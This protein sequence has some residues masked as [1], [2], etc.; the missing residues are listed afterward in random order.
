LFH[1]PQR[2]I[3][4]Q[5]HLV[6]NE[7][8]IKQSHCIKYLGIY[9]DSNLSWKPQVEYIAKKNKKK[10][11]PLIKASVLCNYKNLE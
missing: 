9:I 4:H 11:W 10:H 6:S 1:A 3:K 5:F 8:I 7:K 2:K